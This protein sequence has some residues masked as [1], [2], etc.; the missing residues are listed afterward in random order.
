MNNQNTFLKHRAQ[1]VIVVGVKELLE[2]NLSIKI[3]GGEGTESID[4]GELHKLI[5]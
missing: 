1:T 5:N 3:D 2:N 4:M